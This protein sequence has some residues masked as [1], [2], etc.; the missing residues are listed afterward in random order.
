MSLT[1]QDLVLIEQTI[2]VAQSRGAFQAPEMSKIGTV[3]DKI[4]KILEEA[5]EREDKEREARE[6]A[7]LPTVDEDEKTPQ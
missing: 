3:Y 7:K 5:K 4:F 6:K 2:R 1:L